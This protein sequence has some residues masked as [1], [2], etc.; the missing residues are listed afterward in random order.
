MESARGNVAYNV[1]RIVLALLLALPS[2]AAAQR[3]VTVHVPPGDAVAFASKGRPT[4]PPADP[5]APKGEIATVTV[6]T[7]QDTLTLW[8]RSLNRLASAP[9]AGAEWT[10]KISD[11]TDLGQVVVEVRRD[12]QPVA[13]ANVTLDDGRR[14][15][16]QLLDPST[17]GDATFF[18]VKPGSLKVTVGYRAKGV[19]AAPVTLL[20]EAKAEGDAPPHFAVALPEAAETLGTGPAAPPNTGALP[21]APGSATKPA[22]SGGFNLVGTFFALLI[23]GAAAFGLWTYIKKNP[24]AVGG[25]LEKLGAQIPKPGNAPLADPAVSAAPAPLAPEPPQ[26]IVLDP[27][28]PVA[29]IAPI[30]MAA[31]AATGEPSLVSLGGI[32]IPLGEGETVVGREVGLGLSLAGESTVSRRHA[33]IV[34]AGGTATLFDEGSTNGTFVNGGRVSGGVALNPGDQVQFGSVRFRYEG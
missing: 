1:P 25:T 29:S 24:D 9:V 11:L 32:P 10:P 22:P 8:D 7:G 31:P 18:A 26:K 19:D 16:T 27:V 21:G 4:A 17:K 30:Q 34:R 15:Q 23:G 6:E 2:L 14:K 28:A 20:F 3:A 12:G 5:S 33:R 13:A